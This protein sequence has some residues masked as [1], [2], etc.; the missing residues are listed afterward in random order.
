MVLITLLIAM[1]T[2]FIQTSKASNM[3]PVNALRYE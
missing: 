3:N 2:T 1:A